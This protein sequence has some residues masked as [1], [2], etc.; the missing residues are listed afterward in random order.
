VVWEKPHPSVVSGRDKGRGPRQQ[1]QTACWRG[2][3]LQGRHLLHRRTGRAPPALP[4]L[5]LDEQEYL[6]GP[7]SAPS[8]SQ[9]A[10]GAVTEAGPSPSPFLVLREQQG[11]AEAREVEGRRH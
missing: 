7:S 11:W 9:Q 3:H 5:A 1:R 2:R 4:P 8:G 6:Q 10:T